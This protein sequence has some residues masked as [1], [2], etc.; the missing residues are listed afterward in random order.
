MYR[1]S[2]WKYWMQGKLPRTPYRIQWNFCSW[3]THCAAASTWCS[4]MAAGQMLGASV[5]SQVTAPLVQSR[6]LTLHDAKLCHILSSLVP[7]M[8]DG[9]L[10]HTT[11]PWRWVRQSAYDRELYGRVRNTLRCPLALLEGTLHSLNPRMQ[12]TFAQPSVL[13]RPCSIT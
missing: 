1:F 4:G 12:P 13:V 5:S 2:K 11:V 3:S 7:Q 6:I 8:Q 9:V 10:C